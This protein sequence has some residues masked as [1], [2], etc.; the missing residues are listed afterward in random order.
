MQ[1]DNQ[2]TNTQKTEVENVQAAQYKPKKTGP[3]NYVNRMNRITLAVCAGFLIL[4]DLPIVISSPMLTPFFLAMLGVTGALLILSI[5]E[6][7]YYK[8]VKP[9]GD[10]FL[11]TLI[12]IRDII[13]ILNVIPFIQ[14]LGLFI[15]GTVGFFLLVAQLIIML[16]LYYKSRKES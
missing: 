7:I 4:V 3:S 5:F 14:L 11:I 1:P 12:V 10:G 16:V 6:A 13:V 9:T 2:H 8:T 15:L